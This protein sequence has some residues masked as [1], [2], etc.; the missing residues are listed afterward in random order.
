MGVKATIMKTADLIELIY[1]CYYRD[2]YSYA[3]AIYDKEPFSLFVEAQQDH[4][5]NVPKTKMLD[6]ILGETINQIQLANIDTD[7]AGK[8][9]LMEIEELREKYAGYFQED[10]GGIGS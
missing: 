4:F 8:K 1:S 2:D 10:R 9:T 5:K 3:Q 6:L 7:P